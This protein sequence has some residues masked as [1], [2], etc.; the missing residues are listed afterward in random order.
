MPKDFFAHLSDNN[1]PPTYKFFD[2]Q[3]WSVSTS[4]K[5]IDVVSPIDD[6]IIGRIQSVTHAQADQSIIRAKKAQKAWASFPMIKRG[7]ILHLVSDW[8]REHE[9]YLTTLLMKE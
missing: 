8:I 3:Q 6:Q 5:T 7:Q 4:G 2:G 9:S 1:T